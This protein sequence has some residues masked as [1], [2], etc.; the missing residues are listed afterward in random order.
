MSL[1][2]CVIRAAHATG[3]EHYLELGIFLDEFQ[4]F[5][6]LRYSNPLIFFV[7]RLQFY[8][9]ILNEQTNLIS[10][11]TIVLNNVRVKDLNQ[12][13]SRFLRSA[14]GG[15]EMDQRLMEPLLRY[16]EVNLN[17][18]D[19]LKENSKRAVFIKN[20]RLIFDECKKLYI[21]RIQQLKRAINNRSTIPDPE[22]FTSEYPSETESDRETEYY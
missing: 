5:Y 20:S 16:L 11:E 17:R 22:E 7:Q 18:I 8:E 14:N 19:E 12:I 10:L 3:N 21:L 2:S 9:E 15:V 1:R 13:K 6:D 4:K